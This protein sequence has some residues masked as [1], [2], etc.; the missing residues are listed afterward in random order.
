MPD[1]PSAW[2]SCSLEHRPRDREFAAKRVS[3]RRDKWVLE[4]EHPHDVRWTLVLNTKAPDACLE[5]TRGGRTM[6]FP[7]Y[8]LSGDEKEFTFRSLLDGDSEFVWTVRIVGSD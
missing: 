2:I 3:R 6:Q 8:D 7:T 4:F 5:R 1:E